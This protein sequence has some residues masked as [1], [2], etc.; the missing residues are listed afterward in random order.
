MKRMM[1]SGVSPFLG[2]LLALCLSLTIPLQ[3]WG[4]AKTRVAVIDFEQKGEQEFRGKQVGEIVAEWLITSLVRTGRFDVVERA[5]LQK[6]L[7]EQQ[8][9]MSGM[10][11]QETASKVGELLGVKVIITGSVIRLG[12]IYDVNTR[13]IKVE[14][15]S[16]LKAEKIRGPGLD[17]IER[18]MD[19]L[20]DT[21]KKDF[22]IEGYVVMVTGKRAM[23]D[24]GKSHG[25]EPG[26][27]FIAFRQGAPV[28]HPVTG[29]MLK[30]EDIKI[31][32]M[33]VQ[34]VQTDTSWAEITKEEP[35]AK[36]AAGN[37]ARSSG[38]EGVAPAPVVSVQPPPSRPAPIAMKMW[39]GKGRAEKIVADWNGDGLYDLILGDS[40]GYVTVYL[41]QG[42]NDS[43]KYAVGMK[44]RGGGKEIKVRS[45]SVPY[46][47]DWN[48]DGK[49]D[50]LV[51]NGGGYLHF[52]PNAGSVD[53]L[54]FAPGVMVQAAG[55]DLDV[56][57]K[58]SPCVI[59]WNEDGKIDLLMGNG[60][61]EIFL[62]LNEGSNEQPVFGKPIKLNG[63]SLDVGSTSSPE[64]VDWNGDGKKDLII[65]NADGEIIVF[66]NKGTNEDPQYDN[67]GEKLPLKFGEDVSP[68]VIGWNRPGANDLVV[69]DR[70][71]EVTLYVNTGTPQS[72][73]F[74]EKKVLRAGK[75]LRR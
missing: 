54:D 17:A 24:L 60:S 58:A 5:Q 11:S 44:L 37:L 71:G 6:I 66:L 12:N 41:N 2:I 62:Y 30:G 19:S 61:G 40:D 51:G 15:G 70:N 55:K 27:Q 48:G 74:S 14:D 53:S 63:G 47:V 52:F 35:G 75:P 38:L 9:G 10:I 21:I 59:D 23:I 16:I 69:A 34:T 25:V 50:L 4:A 67:K 68:R 32:E 18:M 64:V 1:M 28:R 46:L 36:I 29:K 49:I 7:Q 45:P 56:G 3:C 31:G 65:G 33:S 39:A 26:M 20:A 57:G 22:P 43:P 42:T 72:P 73:A 13:L 8:M